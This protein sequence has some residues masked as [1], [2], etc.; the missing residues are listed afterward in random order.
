MLKDGDIQSV[1]GVLYRIYDVVHNG[2]DGVRHCYKSAQDPRPDPMG[3]HPVLIKEAHAMN[4]LPKIDFIYLN[5]QDMIKAGVT[6]MPGCVDC[7]EEMFTLLHP[8]HMHR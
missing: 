5:E 8:L 1:F 6:D 2:R 7:M 4:A 3:R